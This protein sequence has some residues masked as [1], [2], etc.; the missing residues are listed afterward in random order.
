MTE[1]VSYH[2][3]Q[4]CGNIPDN[5]WN[6]IV[7]HALNCKP[8]HKHYSYCIPTTD[9]IVFINSLYNIVGAKINGIYTSYE[10][11]NDT[12][13][14]ITILFCSVFHISLK[15]KVKLNITYSLFLS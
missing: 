15:L 11:L 6:I 7:E 14:V 10:E 1:R 3:V 9:V 2:S 4:A 13:K 8:G 5:D 12:H